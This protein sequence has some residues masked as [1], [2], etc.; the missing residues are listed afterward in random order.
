MD[1][2]IYN[3]NEYKLVV[4]EKKKVNEPI[5]YQQT[6]KSISTAVD[7]CRDTTHY[8]YQLGSLCDASKNAKLRSKR[9]QPSRVQ[10][11]HRAGASWSRDTVRQRTSTG[12]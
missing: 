6:G 4:K 10:H 5:F 12:A 11:H 7:V 1:L 3:P 8:V 2:K 9:E